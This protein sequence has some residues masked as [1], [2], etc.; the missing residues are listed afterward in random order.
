MSELLGGRES[1]SPQ[2]VQRRLLLRAAACGAPPPRQLLE[3]VPADFP[4]NPAC[5][6]RRDHA[7]VERHMDTTIRHG[8]GPT[9]SHGR[10]DGGQHTFE[11]HFYAR[12]RSCDSV[13]RR[14]LGALRRCRCALTLSSARHD[15]CSLLTRGK[16]CPRISVLRTSLPSKGLT[17]TFR[18]IGQAAIQLESTDRRMHDS[19]DKVRVAI[20][21]HGCKSRMN[22]VRDTGSRGRA[23]EGNDV[24][25]ASRSQSHRR[26]LLSPMSTAPAHELE[27]VLRARD[28]K[29]VLTPKS[30]GRADDHAVL[31]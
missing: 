21:W 31:C 11:G 7:L 10:G 1:G 3:I 28:D 22:R 17:D 19:T 30:A 27:A 6:A 12:C 4:R 26:E 29:A 5:D 15:G 23:G 25:T 16:L 13:A 24:S 18:N 14:D 8:D 2:I 9:A 20:E